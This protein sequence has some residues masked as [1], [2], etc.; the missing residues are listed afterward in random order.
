MKTR[1]ASQS[2]FCFLMTHQI[3]TIATRMTNATKNST[4]DTVVNAHVSVHW[5]LLDSIN[6]FLPQFLFK[7]LFHNFT[8]FILFFSLLRH[9]SLLNSITVLFHCSNQNRI[10]SVFLKHSYN[11]HCV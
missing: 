3:K 5:L 10:L 8:A 2:R 6:A 9:W 11:P 7:S 4:L 1:R